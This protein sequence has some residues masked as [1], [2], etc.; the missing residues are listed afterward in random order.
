MS[1]NQCNKEVVLW[2]NKQDW[3]APGKSD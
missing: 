3:Q 1:K 2:K